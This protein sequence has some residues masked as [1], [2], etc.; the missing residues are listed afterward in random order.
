MRERA[1]ERWR[2]QGLGAVLVGIVLLTGAPPAMAAAGDL[3]P[4]FGT[5]GKVTQSFTGRYAGIEAVAFQ[6]DGKIVAV[7]SATTPD[8]DGEFVVSRYNVDGTPDATFNGDGTFAMGLVSG[9]CDETL[10]DVAIQPDGKIVAVG[11]SYDHGALTYSPVLI[12]LRPD[13]RL[14]GT[15]GNGGVVLDDALA[16]SEADAVALQPDGK[17]VVAGKASP[18]VT[19]FFVARYGTDGVPDTT[20]SGDGRQRTTFGG[21]F[22][23]AED[24]AVLDGGKILAVGRADDQTGRLGFALA[25]YTLKGGLDQSFGTRGRVLSQLGREGAWAHSVAILPG[26]HILVGGEVYSRSTGSFAVARYTAD[27]TL[28]PAY[29][30]GD[31]WTRTPLDSGL[32]HAFGMALQPDGKPI[33]AG[34]ATPGNQRYYFTLV[35]YGLHGAVDRTFGDNGI[36]LTSFG[37][38]TGDGDFAQAVAVD[39]QGRIL[40]GGFTGEGEFALARYLGA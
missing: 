23:W 35:R 21:G 26:K 28:D 36:V 5:G 24:V 39:D 38:T 9:C 33:L 11:Y 18:D 12:R 10:L 15:F 14:D 32:T 2:Q 17:I 19:R 27:G 1:S 3:D 29:G 25:R 7:G 8:G 16:F 40:A 13:G 37:P 34:Y 4:S 20:F 31:G 30:G 22:A 6:S